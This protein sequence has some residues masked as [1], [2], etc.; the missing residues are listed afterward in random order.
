[1][2]GVYRCVLRGGYARTNDYQ[3]INLAL[4]VASSFPYVAAIGQSNLP[5][6]FAVLPT[7]RPDLSSPAALNL[8]NRTVLAEDFRSPVAEQ[9][10]MEIQRQMALNTVFRVGYVGTKGSGLFQT[11]DGN[12]RTI[13][14]TP[15]SCPR[16]DPTRGTIRLRANASSS[17]YHSMQVSADRRFAA[18]GSW[19]G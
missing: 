18:G 8:L 6:A 4:N 12:P 19:G 7:L 16:V 3:F 10:T 9:F 5:N 15:P 2:A 1:L 14:G 13:C 11:L 17:T